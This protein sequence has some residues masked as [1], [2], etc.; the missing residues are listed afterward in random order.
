[1]IRDE[2]PGDEAAISALITRAFAGSRHGDS[3]EARI[4]EALR[5]AGARSLSRVATRDGRVIG[6]V[7][8]SPVTIADRTPHWFGLGPV[9]VEPGE[10]RTG[11]GAALIEDGLTRLRD[12]GARGCVVGGDD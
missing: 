8:F 10:Q 9:A 2:R 4:V 6:H 12:Q 5:A 3:G 7:A 1:M 11:I